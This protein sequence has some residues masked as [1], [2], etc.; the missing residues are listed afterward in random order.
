MA[1][2]IETIL[3]SETRG[4]DDHHDALRLWLRILTCTNLVE[5][6]LRNNL[7]EEFASTLPRFDLL[8]QLERNPQGLKMGDLSKLMMVSGGNVTGI[9]TQDPAHEERYKPD[10]ESRNIHRFLEAVR[11]QVAAITGALGHDDVRGLS[12]DDLVAL[13]PE[14]AAITG[15]AYEPEHRDGSENLAIEMRAM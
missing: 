3:D 13:T 14:A 4:H 6:K 9:A 11:F 12:R 1:A 15:L 8:A 5:N 7:R 2:N 10:I